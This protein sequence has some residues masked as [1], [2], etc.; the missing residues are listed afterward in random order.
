MTRLLCT[1]A[2]ALGFLAIAWMGSTFVGSDRLALAVIVVIG[3]V[4]CIG[5]IEMLQ[6]RRATSTL[7]A[8]LTHKH[9]GDEPP[10]SD[11]TGWLDDVHPSLQLA[12]RR[13]IEGEPVGLPAPVITPYLVGLLVMLGLLGTFAGMVDTLQGAVL[14]LEGTTELQ[15]IRAGLTAPI[16]GLSLA[17]G[18]S[19]AGIA[20]SAMLGLI[21]TLSRRDRIVATRQLDRQTKDTLLHFSLH[22]Q[23]QQAFQALQTQA[24]VL[25]AVAQGLQLTADQLELTGKS[26]G[27]QLLINQQQLH[28][29]TTHTFTEL[30]ASVECS[31][32][33]SLTDSARQAGES[34]QPMVAQTMET[35]RQSTAS[36]QQQLTHCVETQLEALTQRFG[37]SGEQV[38]NA[39]QSGLAA[40]RQADAE[41]IGSLQQTGTALH[42]DIRQSGLTL[43][44]SLEQSAEQRQQLQMQVDQ[45]RLRQWTEVLAQT[46][47][48]G[49]NRLSEASTE[50][51][52]T[53]ASLS[54]LQH[55]ALE[56]T[57]ERIA[58]AA[59]SL[60]E[61]WLQA[62]EQMAEL[63]ATFTS[64]LTVL[65]QNE[66]ARGQAAVDRLAALESSAATQ[67]AALG[68]TLE[69]PMANLIETAAETP[70]AATAAITTM[71][72]ELSNSLARDNDLLNE[73]RHLF[74]ELSAASNSIQASSAS[75]QDAVERLVST[76]ADTLQQ[77]SSGFSEQIASG[78]SSVAGTADQFNR[79]AIDIASLSDAFGSAVSLFGAS[80]SQLIEQLNS[81]EQAL[82]HATARS[83]EQMGYYV[84]QAR[85]IIDQTL[86]AQQQLVDQLHSFNPNTEPL[87]A[88]AG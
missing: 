83:D 56:S 4:Y 66:D 45:E 21:S 40:H 74:D 70:R 88:E 18:T 52:D 77:V 80:N 10:I 41:L 13:R 36:T 19:V 23:R 55:Q 53:I 9:D 87:A 68:K 76:A 82:S 39:W 57:A 63:T 43:L 69:T 22:Y 61:G 24:Q 73:R 30:A 25:P 81:I 11:L 33:R 12:V 5:Y 46:Q 62:G 16:N 59:N 34:I 32:Q 54:S 31:L 51:S 75:Q 6:F 71:R 7:T 35:I 38:A 64:E 26:I 60:T 15:A 27:E 8:K 44:A 14:A 67:L 29:N 28:Q 84:A 49:L 47:Q 37:Q 65:R 79:S 1:T 58:G 50:A 86:L 48:Q 78:L 2:F 20:A 3:C 17:F 85:E 42:H 72:Q